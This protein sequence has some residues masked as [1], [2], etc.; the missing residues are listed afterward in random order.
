MKNLSW[1]TNC[2]NMSTRPR[3]SFNVN[4]VC[5]AC[6]WSEK[7]KKIDWKKRN[8]EFLKIVKETRNSN[9]TSFDAIVPV[10]GGKDGS[11]VAYQIK[12]KYKLNPLTVTVH[13][14]LR[15][16][17]GYK[18][19]ENFKKKGFDLLEISLP[20]ENLRKINKFSFI[21]HGKPTNGWTVGIFSA[22]ARVAEQFKINLIIYGED[23][24]VEYGGTTH[25]EK[26]KTFSIDYLKKVY[27]EG[28]HQKI[29]KKCLKTEKKRYWWTFP[30]EK[31]SKIR[32][33]HWSNF[34]NWDPYKHYVTAKTYCG[35]EGKS[36]RNTGT[37]TNFA[38]NDSHLQGLHYYLMYLKFGFGRATQDVGI[39]IRRGAMSRGQAVRLVEIYNNEYP[40]MDLEKCRE[41]FEMT[42]SSFNK[43]LDKFANKDLFIKKNN[44]W[45][46]K[47]KIK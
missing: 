33:T 39:D 40:E 29:L 47:F 11:H 17:L 4:G 1:C 23:G 46:P 2:L 31:K 28:K 25:Q 37:Y 38:Q 41:Y 43:V 18:N 14:P 9:D 42:K 15:T 21:D 30:K 24:E 6:I 8:K 13:P 34:E 35:Y 22:V 20:Y 10:S 32:M 26:K 19:L 12:E 5:N 16:E 3:I 36:D 7:K 27:L 44:F 45:V